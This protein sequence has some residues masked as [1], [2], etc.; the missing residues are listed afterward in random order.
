MPLSSPNSVRASPN[1][2]QATQPAACAGRPMK[3][4]AIAAHRLLG[5]I[6]VRRTGRVCVLRTLGVYVAGPGSG[7]VKVKPAEWRQ[8]N[9]ERHKLFEK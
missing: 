1:Q 2:S 6:F 5:F 8:A 3:D 7:R 4:L 9:Q